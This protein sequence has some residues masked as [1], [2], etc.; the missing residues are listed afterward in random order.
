MARKRK[1]GVSRIAIRKHNK[2]RLPSSLERLVY[3]WLT[4]DNIPYRREVKVGRCHVDIV[5]GKKLAIE[6][7]GCYWH[8]CHICFPNTTKKM[9]MK[10]FRD[11][12]RYNFLRKRGFTVVVLWEHELLDTPD[13]MREQIRGLAKTI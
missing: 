10:R 7:A 5:L 12:K 2:K 8:F 1:K 6:L 13:K 3:A 4:E 11:I 9:Q